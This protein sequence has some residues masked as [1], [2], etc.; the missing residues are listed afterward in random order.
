MRWNLPSEK[1]NQRQAIAVS[2]LETDSE[3]VRAHKA[4]TRLKHPLCSQPDNNK[5]EDEKSKQSARA[6]KLCEDAGWLDSVVDT[7]G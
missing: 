4:T 5:S 2:V 6:G 1:I 7:A 3:R